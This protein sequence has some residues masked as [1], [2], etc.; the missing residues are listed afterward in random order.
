MDLHQLEVFTAIVEEGTLSAAAK[1]LHCSQP[2]LSYQLSNLEKELNVTLIQRGSRQCVC[3]EAGLQLY[4]RALQ[5]LELSS[6][7]AAELQQ[8]GNRVSGTLRIGVISSAVSVLLNQQLDQFHQQYPLI[9]FQLF[10]GNTFELLEELKKG[11]LDL[12][13]VRTPFK[14]DVV[15][16]H[17]QS[18]AML[19]VSTQ[20][21]CGHESITIQELS[22]HPLIIY[23]RFEKLVRTAFADAGC[24]LQ[25]A[26]LN[27]DARTTYC[28][29]KAG[30]GVGLVPASLLP[31]FASD[32]LAA[33]PI[34]EDSFYTQIVVTYKSRDTLAT[35]ARCFLSHMEKLLSEEKKK[36]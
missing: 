17:L 14:D 1:R 35:P 27:D 9:T 7:A 19:A 36:T 22:K 30:I 34:A 31:M 20:P 10:E 2:P 13:I 6:L 15:K 29:A 21:L 32:N 12:A 8:A 18:E 25:L 3:T 16:L 28:W 4:K 23:R 5:I 24:E 33:V 26:C 11:L